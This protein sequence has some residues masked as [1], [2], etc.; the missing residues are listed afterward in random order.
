MPDENDYSGA[1]HVVLPVVHPNG[2]VH[3]V[4]VHEDTPLDELHESLVKSGYAADAE[5]H[6]T[7]AD[8]NL[9]AAPRVSGR[10][11]ATQSEYLQP[12]IPP[13]TKEG[14]VEHDPRFKDA[15]AQ[16]WRTSNRGK[17]NDEVTLDLSKDLERGTL[18]VSKG[19]GHAKVYA[20]AD[21]PY[22]LHTHDNAAGGQPSPQ[23]IDTAKR[24]KK[25]IYVVSKSGL[26]Y[27][28]PHGEVGTVY[29][30]PSEFGGDK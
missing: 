17:D 28:G 29:H 12:D 6:K 23:D 1:T 27:A 3:H 22:F 10:K 24:L 15:A 16:I 19:K 13:P 21:S 8:N 26:Q 11:Y 4:A 18:G 5:I 30:S 20:P 9:A 25:Y 7:E 2:E 14:S